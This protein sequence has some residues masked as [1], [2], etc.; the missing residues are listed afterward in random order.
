MHYMKHHAEE[1]E[2]IQVK[3]KKGYYAVEDGHILPGAPFYPSEH[4]FSAVDDPDFPT[5]R[6]E[7]DEEKYQQAERGA[8]PFDPMVRPT[9]ASAMY[10]MEARRWEDEAPPRKRTRTPSPPRTRRNSREESRR[11]TD[12]RS[13]GGGD[14]WYQGREPGAAGG[15]PRDDHPR[16]VQPAHVQYE[17]NADRARKAEAERDAL[18][19]R[20][21][22]IEEDLSQSMQDVEDLWR[23][24]YSA[25]E[26]SHK[27][28]LK[29]KAEMEQKIDLMMLHETE[30]ERQYKE[31]SDRCRAQKDSLT[32]ANQAEQR[33]VSA[34]QGDG[35][36]I[37]QLRRKVTS[38]RQEMAE[39]A[40]IEAAKATN[41]YKKKQEVTEHMLA[42][43][44]LNMEEAEE[45]KRQ[46]DERLRAAEQDVEN[47]QEC[48]ERAIEDLRLEKHANK[49]ATKVAMQ[50]AHCQDQERLALQ[51][52]VTEIRL[53]AKE[54]QEL[55][56]S[57][58]LEID[59][60]QHQVERR[61][62]QLTTAEKEIRLV[63]EQS[64]GKQEE[65]DALT[66]SLE[67]LK[68]QWD[69]LSGG[70]TSKP[71]TMVGSPETLALFPPVEDRETDQVQ[72]RRTLAVAYDIRAV[73]RGQ[74]FE[75]PRHVTFD[76]NVLSPIVRTSPDELMIYLEKFTKARIDEIRMDLERKAFD[77]GVLE[78]MRR[79]QMADRD[80]ADGIILISDSDPF[81]DSE[82]IP[83]SDAE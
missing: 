19:Q 29:T 78:G 43:A 16:G 26:E 22:G 3:W 27:A 50:A 37:Q 66:T 47:Y 36:T 75:H 40:G 44:L 14:N 53:E 54:A 56:Q 20:I 82:P 80:A 64:A 41:S 74:V 15:Y 23:E 34:R 17:A 57:C 63:Q 21:Q 24:K 12:R 39:W 13:Y 65:I 69:E 55:V 67:D 42:E 2:C 61:E 31:L 76:A 77:R 68:L 25:L 8:T 35:R 1:L 10:R 11:D 59:H 83:D 52:Q 73:Q 9:S 33:A 45:A 51:K 60:M 70:R 79:Q 71:R 4:P 48:C 49:E 6:L 28:S 46:L 5:R 32:L 72:V 18:A 30:I 81:S 62:R 7:I 38:I 58:R